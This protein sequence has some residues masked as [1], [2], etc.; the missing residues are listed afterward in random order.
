MS[1]S[2]EG[3]V[4]GLVGKRGQTGSWNRSARVFT[5][6]ALLVEGGVRLKCEYSD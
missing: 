5:K 4:V 6:I 1:R 2:G 3:I